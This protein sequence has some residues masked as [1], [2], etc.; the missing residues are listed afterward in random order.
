[1]NMCRFSSKEDGGYSVFKDGLAFCLKAI[2]VRNE[3]RR[4]GLLEQ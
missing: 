1:M 2:V 3:E 4:E